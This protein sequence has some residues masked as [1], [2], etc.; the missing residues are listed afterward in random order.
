MRSNDQFNTT[1]Y[2]YTDRLCGILDSRMIVMINRSDRERLGI[3]EGGTAR[4]TTAVDDGIERSVGGFQTIDYDI[5]PGTLAA[6]YPECNA[7]IPLWQ[8][9]QES[10][11]PAAKS[12][13]DLK[14]P[15]REWR[16]AVY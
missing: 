16:N 15:S 4:L 9:A 1:V 8:F 7:L 11:T 6:Y 10:K 13:L 12:T 3:A 2:G 14:Q 5:P